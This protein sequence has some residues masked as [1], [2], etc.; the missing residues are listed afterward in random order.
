MLSRK[1]ILAALFI[2]VA[3]NASAMRPAVTINFGS[4]YPTT[5]YYPS[6]VYTT[7]YVPTYY[8]TSY[9]YSYSPTWGYYDDYY[10]D[11]YDSPAT[12]LV[13]AC[14]VTG[15]LA[16]ALALIGAIVNH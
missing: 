11:Y 10:W 8:P 13:K 16:L 4:Y 6:P 12:A 14:A 9:G 2:F 3:G 7:T 15:V 5:P 1:Y